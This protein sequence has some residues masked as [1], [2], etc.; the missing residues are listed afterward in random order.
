MGYTPLDE[1][2]I[3]STVFRQGPMVF[4]VWCAVLA[5]ADQDGM[6]ALNPKAL[7]LLWD[8]KVHMKH[9]NEAWDRLTSPDPDSKNRE[10]AGRRIIPTEDGR[11]FVVS[12]Q[13]YRDKFRAEVRRM[14]VA[15]AK[16]R[17]RERDAG[18]MC[19]EC[20]LTDALKPHG[21]SGRVFCKSHLP[22]KEASQ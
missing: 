14:Q 11:W 22:K 12:H 21:D 18:R 15:D 3:Y 6:T 9:I 20:D 19:S 10:H 1:E 16:R 4:A 7:E 8:H 17:Q 2:V 13:K 5:A